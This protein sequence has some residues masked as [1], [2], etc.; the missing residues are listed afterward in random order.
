VNAI[1][2]HAM[3]TAWWATCEPAGLLAAVEGW[4]TAWDTHL[5]RFRS[6]SAL[7]RLNRERTLEDP[8]LAELVGAALAARTATD[9]AFDPTL[10]ARL[11]ALGYDRDFARIRRP[12]V[13][14]LPPVGALDVHLEGHRIHLD[15][16]GEIDLGGIA[17]GWAV[18]RVFDRL[19]ASGASAVLVD[20]GGDLRVRG[21]PWPI[22]TPD[23]G[24][25]DL[26]DGALAT[27]SVERRSWV[28]ATGD[29][30]HHLLDPA[31]GL[32]AR[33]GL[34]EVSVAAPT[35]VL[36]DVLAEAILVRPALLPCLG[37]LAARARVR[38]AGGGWWESE[39]WG[40]PW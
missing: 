15:G 19:V 16:P 31:T 2:F 20:G 38:A 30:L 7:S 33:G 40:T 1:A 11:A 35:A 37:P 28:D 18:D 22:G 13:R 10:G 23:G 8:L 12:A 24:A 5:S 27:S 26:T 25:I 14:V 6:D 21:G 9:G 29:P 3:G 39:D 4:V 32:P 34:A 36:A 17:K